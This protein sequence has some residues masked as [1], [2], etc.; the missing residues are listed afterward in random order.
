MQANRISKSDKVEVTVVD[1]KGVDVYTFDGTG[2][3]NVAQAIA[4]AFAAYSGVNLNT[5]RHFDDSVEV[6]PSFFHYYHNPDAGDNVIE[7]FTF[8]V[9]NLTEGTE[10]RYRV[11][12]GGHPR[13]IV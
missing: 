2:Y 9:K 12:A 8:K 11:N 4:A 5:P 6:E 7:G 13:L 1:S 10:S 3:H